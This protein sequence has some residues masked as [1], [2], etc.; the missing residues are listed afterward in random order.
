[1]SLAGGPALV[2]GASAG[3]GRAYAESLAA[4]G[5]D[6]LLVARREDRLRALAADLSA[7]HG[8]AVEVAACD[9]ARKGGLARCRAAIDA[10]GPLA[11]AVLNAGF[12]SR[13][14]FTALDRAMEAD[15]VRLNCV[16]VVDLA[17]HVLPPMVSRGAGALVVM[18]SAAAFQPLP[19]MAT[20]GATKAFE[21]SFAEAL[22]E[23]L[24]GGGVRVLSVCPGPTRTE[25]SE[26]AGGEAPLRWSMPMDDP[27]DVVAATWGALAAGRRRVA[28]GRVA[29]L[30][31]AASRTLP[32]G[33]VLRAA[34]RARSREVR[35]ALKGS[36]ART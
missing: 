19:F 20:Y 28:T 32:R 23:E 26:V 3:L 1:M 7:R 9:L 5:R 17:A 36:R 34:G 27:R 25:F 35:G 16:A 10:A 18:S 21:L 13:G 12:G 11:L 24:R 15:M 30:A 22:S 29:R 14:P 4:R 33:V 8:V 2:T 6:L 31:Q